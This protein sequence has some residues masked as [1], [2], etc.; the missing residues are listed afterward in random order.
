MTYFL[1]GWLICLTWYVFRKEQPEN[2][3]W[4]VK[5]KRTTVATSGETAEFIE[6]DRVGAII[7]EKLDLVID[8]ILT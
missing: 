1:V 3:T 2:E 7:K 6:N 8:D 4:T 5:R